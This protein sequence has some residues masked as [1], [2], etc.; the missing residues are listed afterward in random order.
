MIKSNYLRK[1]LIC[2][3]LTCL[4]F[5]CED[6]IDT[7]N[8]NDSS[9]SQK[10]SSYD[11]LISEGN[12]SLF[13]DAVERTDYTDLLKGKG[14]STLFAPTDS[15]V[16]NYLKQNNHNSIADIDIEKLTGMI[17]FHFMKYGFNKENILAFKP[18]GVITETTPGVFFKHQTYSQR[19]VDTAFNRR[20]GSNVSVFH[21]TKYIPLFTDNFF[22]AYNISNHEKNYNFFFPSIEWIG[23]EDNCYGP[24]FSI[25]KYEHPTDNGY[26]YHTDHFIEPLK[27]IT[28]ELE[29][30]ERFSSTHQLYNYF[31]DFS[32][33]KGYTE[34]YGFEGDSLYNL[35]HAW[36]NIVKIPSL[37]FEWS[38]VSDVYQQLGKY[39]NS[40][41]APTNDAWASF[42]KTYFPGQNKTFDNLSLVVKYYLAE[43][44]AKKVEG[45]LLPEMLSNGYPT[46]WG[47]TYNLDPWTEI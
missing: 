25:S 39:S 37:S 21:R 31:T 19:G 42:F 46:S 3:L 5:A 23:N 20:S 28:E 18:D 8:N 13:L 27:T 6:D 7:G 10:G 43:N 34:D 2:L 35:L 4:V 9:S 22:N 47:G 41:L 1:E 14:M 24:G 29:S 33:D 30:A 38:T 44:H 17:G 36:G 32:F 15:A 16:M 11:Y 12:F 45:L 26:V 40:L